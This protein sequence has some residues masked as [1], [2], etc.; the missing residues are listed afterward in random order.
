MADQ[1]LVPMDDSEMAARALRHALETR[2]DAEI[3]VLN[4]V[5]KS[6]PMMGKAVGLA[7]EDNFE[8]AAEERASEVFDRANE[9]A[10]E[11]EAEIHTK[12][13]VGQPAGTI[14][15]ESAAFDGIFLG[16]HSRSLIDRLL[17]GNVAKTVVKQ[18]PVP[19]TV[20]Q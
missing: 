9:I 12:V 10:A 19:V 16:S 6:T 18:A 15:E 2:G 3:T 11:Y 4:V 5:G 8:D 13:A 14:V 1:I 7:L 17:V 20:V